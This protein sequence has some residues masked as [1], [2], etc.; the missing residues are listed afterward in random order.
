MTIRIPLVAGLLC[1]SACQQVGQGNQSPIA[2][3]NS[4]NAATEIAPAAANAANAAT[5]NQV[6]AARHETTVP[7]TRGSVPADYD[8]NFVIHGGSGNLDYGDG[9]WSEGVSLLGLSCAPG[10]GRVNIS[11]NGDGPARIVAGQES[12]VLQPGSETPINHPLL[13]A[14]HS[15]G[16]VSVIVGEEELALVAKPAGRQHLNDFLAYCGMR[17]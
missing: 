5:V 8:W 11:W 17:P 12:A 13:R 15:S 10:L 16:T 6:T 9:D 4:G 14:L 3:G 2:A 1:L 7:L